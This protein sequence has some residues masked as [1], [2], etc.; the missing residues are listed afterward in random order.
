MTTYNHVTHALLMQLGEHQKHH[1]LTELEKDTLNK[2]VTMLT[3]S[4]YLTEQQMATLPYPVD[5]LTLKVK[6]YTHYETK[7]VLN[8][9]Y[10]P[11]LA[12]SDKL[13]DMVNRLEDTIKLYD[14][15]L[16][17]LYEYTP[18]KDTNDRR[19]QRYAHT[20]SMRVTQTQLEPNPVWSTFRNLFSTIMHF[21]STDETPAV[22]SWIHDRS[23][24]V[25]DLKLAVFTSYKAM[26]LAKDWL[27]S[28]LESYTLHAGYAYYKSRIDSSPILH[29]MRDHQPVPI[30]HTMKYATNAPAPIRP[31]IKNLVMH[32][33]ST[34][35]AIRATFNYFVEAHVS[36]YQPHNE[37]KYAFFK[38]AVRFAR[39]S[40]IDTDE[41]RAYADLIDKV[42]NEL[43]SYLEV[44][45]WSDLDD[46]L[47][48]CQPSGLTP[49]TLESYLYSLVAHCQHDLYGTP[50]PENVMPLTGNRAYD[51]ATYLYDD[52]E[53][54]LN[55]LTKV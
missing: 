16:A 30:L 54:Y 22:A 1:T 52:V 21:E 5:G 50:L 44:I 20:I 7:P 12:L 35:Q 4:G 6:A 28:Q 27:T 53:A 24:F 31:L 55:R 18:E 19:I 3:S 42:D 11:E 36:T 38:F 17:I 29:D 14:G 9:T 51:L 41:L 40:G 15:I 39:N 13:R 45:E 43:T 47:V 32:V 8:H 26:L 37:F 46:V 49:F 2:H 10:T 34:D 25:A 23:T 33:F 48:L